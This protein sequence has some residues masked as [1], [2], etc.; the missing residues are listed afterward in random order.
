MANTTQVNTHSLQVLLRLVWS[1]W[2]TLDHDSEQDLVAALYEYAEKIEMETGVK[3]DDLPY[4]E[5][6]RILR[7][8]WL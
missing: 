2:A 4:D 8:A 6:V 3:G 7:G 1:A 5:F